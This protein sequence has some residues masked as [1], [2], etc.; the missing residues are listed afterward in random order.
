MRKL[1]IFLL[2]LLTLVIVFGAACDENEKSNETNAR[3]VYQADLSQVDDPEQALKNAM[4]VIEERLDTY[5]VSDPVIRQL[6]DDRIEIQLTS[7]EGLEEALPLIGETALITFKTFAPSDKGDFVIGPNA[8][9]EIDLVPV[10][11]GTGDYIA[12]PVIEEV[13]GQTLELTSQLFEGN[14][15]V[16]IPPMGGPEM[17]F[18][19]T[20]QGAEL[21]YEVTARLSA[22]PIGSVEGRLGIF[23]GDQYISAPQVLQP[24]RDAGVITGM[25]LKDAKDLAKLLNAGRIPIPLT[26]VER[27]DV[28]RQ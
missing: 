13:N 25:R 23:L 9:G 10:P 15:D 7:L 8:E 24:I 1:S 27:K 17:R 12:T 11:A 16:W 19:W 28:P 2:S 6:G 22:L 21:F 26:V 3:I 18:K 20:T 4:R 14:V 5:G